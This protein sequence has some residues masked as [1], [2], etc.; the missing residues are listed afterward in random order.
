MAR[1]GDTIAMV[2]TMAK[3]TSKTYD[4]ENGTAKMIVFDDDGESIMDTI[5]VDVVDFATLSDHL[6]LYAVMKKAG[7]AFTSASAPG[8]DGTVIDGI[9]AA[10]D[11]IKSLREGKWIEKAAGVPRDGLAVAAL[12]RIMDDEDKARGVWSKASDEQKKALRSHP[13][14]KAMIATIQLERANAA[15]K[16]SPSITDLL[17]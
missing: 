14:V 16:D 6:T 12:G 15:A 13:E 2:I 7:D 5:E 11:V 17:G 3:R 1:I 10:N 4:V 8:K 9:H